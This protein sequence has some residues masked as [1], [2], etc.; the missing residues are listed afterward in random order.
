MYFTYRYDFHRG[1]D[2]PKEFG[3]P[4][5][6]I[7]DGKVIIAGYHRSYANGHDPLVQVTNYNTARV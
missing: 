2:I 1:V 5:Y 3:D 7:D 6:A 4:V